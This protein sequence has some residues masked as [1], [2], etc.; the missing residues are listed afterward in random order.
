MV[1]AQLVLLPS[2]EEGNPD[3]LATMIQEHEITMVHFVPSML[4]Y[5]LIT[6]SPQIEW[7]ILRQ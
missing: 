1:G 5:L 2:G 6:L 7:M 4:G 3:K